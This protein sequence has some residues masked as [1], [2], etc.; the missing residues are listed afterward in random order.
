MWNDDP[1]AAVALAYVEPDVGRIR[2]E[3]RLFDE[4]D[5][6][7]TRAT[8]KQVLRPLEHEIPT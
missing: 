3:D 4:E 8:A 6:M 5:A 2:L 7:V 1:H